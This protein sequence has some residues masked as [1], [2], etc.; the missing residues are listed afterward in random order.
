[1]GIGV[2]TE[3]VIDVGSLQ[4]NIRFAAQVRRDR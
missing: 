3:S 1:L 2:V 4:F